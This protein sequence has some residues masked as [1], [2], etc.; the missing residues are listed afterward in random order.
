MRR[1]LSM[2]ATLTAFGCI[3]IGPNATTETANRPGGSPALVFAG[4]NSVDGELLAI[5][6]TAYVVLTPT[7]VVLAPLAI[8]DSARFLDRDRTITYYRELMPEQR[9]N[10]RLISRY[11]PGMPDVALQSLLRARNKSSVTVLTR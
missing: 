7:D 11:P 4:R 10:L 8:V 3:R 5:R 2:L 1:A 6:D 9:E